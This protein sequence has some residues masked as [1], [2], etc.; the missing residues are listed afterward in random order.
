MLFKLYGVCLVFWGFICGGGGGFSPNKMGNMFN[1]TQANHYY[2]LQNGR[3]VGYHY[4]GAS[5]LQLGYNDKL[6]GD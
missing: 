3:E 2:C 1:V 5:L 4:K 6:K